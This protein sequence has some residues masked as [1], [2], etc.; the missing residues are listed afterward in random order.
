[1]NIPA[2]W[3]AKE[4]YRLIEGGEWQETFELAAPGKPYE[5]YS[6]TRLMKAK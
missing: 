3:K 2:G 4:T 1:M 5:V 6:E